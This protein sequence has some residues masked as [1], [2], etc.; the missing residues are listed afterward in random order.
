MPSAVADEPQSPRSPASPAVCVNAR[1]KHSVPH[2]WRDWDRIS[3][4]IRAARQVYLFLDY[5]GTLAPISARRDEARLAPAARNALQRLARLRKVHI[6]ILSGRRRSDIKKRVGVRAVEYLGIYGWDRKEQRPGLPEDVQV[7]LES[8]SRVLARRLEGLPGIEIEDKVHTIAVHHRGATPATSRRALEILQ[9]VLQGLAPPLRILE[10]DM[11]W[12]IVPPQ[13]ESKAVA[14]QAVLRGTRRPF[15]TIY[16]G[17]AVADEE[18]FA[19]V[20]EGI[21]IRVGNRIPTRA[22][23]WLRSPREVQALLLRLLEVLA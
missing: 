4:R 14:V 2:L 3:R 13:V 23:F 21:A 6:V 5:D 8:I 19:T 9:E 7:L 17:D 12:E 11:V 10:G 20:H 1:T 18:A 22:R 16:A 15:L